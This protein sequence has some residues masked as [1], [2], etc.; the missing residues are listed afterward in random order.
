M[1][2]FSSLPQM[3]II[4]VISTSNNII[5]S[6]ICAWNETRTLSYKRPNIMF[7]LA[8]LRGIFSFI[9][10]TAKRSMLWNNIW[11]FQ[12]YLYCKATNG[13]PFYVLRDFPIPGITVIW[14]RTHLPPLLLCIIFTP[15]YYIGYA[16]PVL[17]INST[18]SYYLLRNHTTLLL[19]NHITF[20][21]I[22]DHC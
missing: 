17:S 22:L 11:G 1:F 10:G 19:L 13:F 8:T 3:T 6:K 7:I 5:I 16:C 2:S 12:H 9:S 15:I 14:V 4:S 21:V 18:T 20:S